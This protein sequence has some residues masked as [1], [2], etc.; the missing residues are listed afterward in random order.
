MGTESQETTICCMIN[1]LYVFSWGIAPELWN[2]RLLGLWITQINQV[3]TLAI[4]T[5]SLCVEIQLGWLGWK[6]TVIHRWSVSG[7][8]Y[9]D[10]LNK[11]KAKILKRSARMSPLQIKNSLTKV[12]SEGRN[13]HFKQKSLSLTLSTLW[14]YFLFIRQHLIN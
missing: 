12:K 14:L 13:Y 4:K 9:L 2:C 6:V 3:K 8:V 7:E 10:Y 5:S 1:Y 11:L